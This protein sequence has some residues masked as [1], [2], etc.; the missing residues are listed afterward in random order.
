M[1]RNK[2]GTEQR[3]RFCDPRNFKPGAQLGSAAVAR[4]FQASS[5]FIYSL[6]YLPGSRVVIICTTADHPQLHLWAQ[7]Q[8]SRTVCAV[9]SSNNICLSHPAAAAAQHTTLVL[10]PVPAAVKEALLAKG[11]LP[12]LQASVRSQ[13]FNVLLDS[14]VGV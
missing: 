9:I 11:V 1:Q 2:Q 6:F 7:L 13:I 14:E 3:L 12:S 5:T 4:Q 8:S 10:L